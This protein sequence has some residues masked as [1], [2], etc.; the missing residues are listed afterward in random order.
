[1][2]QLVTLAVPRFHVLIIAAGERAPAR[3]WEFN[4]IRNP[5]TRRGRASIIDVELATN[6]SPDVLELC[7]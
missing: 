1:M 7:L 4:N 6:Q 5:Y 3:F 2:T